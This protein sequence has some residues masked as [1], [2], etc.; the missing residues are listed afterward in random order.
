MDPFTA[1]IVGGM[2]GAIMF[3]VLVRLLGRCDN[4]PQ[5]NTHLT[6]RNV[7]EAYEEAVGRG[8]RGLDG[9]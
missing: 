7:R 9:L 8:H 5:E 3:E 2:Y 1:G 6:T 4:Q